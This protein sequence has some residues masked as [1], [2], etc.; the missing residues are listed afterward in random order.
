M[1]GR[2]NAGGSGASL[3]F[4]VVGNPKPENP[5]ENVLWVNTDNNITGWVFS[6]VT[7]EN[8]TEGVVLIEYDTNG[9][10]GFNALKKN[11]IQ[12]FP[13]SVKQYLSGELVK[14]D[15]QIYQSGVWHELSSREDY[16]VN[17]VMIVE[18]TST[19]NAT[20]EESG[21]ICKINTVSNKKWAV[22]FECNNHAGQT[23]YIEIASGKALNTSNYTSGILVNTVEADA[24]DST[25]DY[26]AQTLITDTVTN[27]I[28]ELKI[29]NDFNSGYLTVHVEPNV[30][31][32]YYNI[33]NLWIE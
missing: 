11:E 25:P 4:K 5:S 32:G 17:G 3:N 10:I 28:Y 20:I 14:K 2:T 24:T 15:A 27:T 31:N 22:N 13:L 30:S 19:Y 26:I 21:G 9:K 1:I 33:K 7:P 23:A 6:G 29:P 16:I 18:P 8:M 12:I